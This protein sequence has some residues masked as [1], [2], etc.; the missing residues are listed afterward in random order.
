MKN[1]KWEYCECGCHGFTIR[2][3]TLTYWSVNTT[4][5]LGHSVYGQ[6]LGDYK[7][8]EEMDVAVVAD[9]TPRLEKLQKELTEATQRLKAAS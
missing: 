2:F 8:N 1:L 6:K 5:F 3:A 7:S 4:L 9:A